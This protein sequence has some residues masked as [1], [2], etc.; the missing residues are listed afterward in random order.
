MAMLKEASRRAT[1]R[2]FRISDKQVARIQADA[3]K[4]GLARRKQ[5]VLRHG[6][7]QIE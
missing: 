2:L 3:V 6:R 5:N 7:T 1:A 4:R